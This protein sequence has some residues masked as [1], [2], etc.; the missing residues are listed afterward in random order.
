MIVVGLGIMFE[1]HDVCA[2]SVRTY[3]V[4]ELSSVSSVVMFTTGEGVFLDDTGSVY[5]TANEWSTWRRIQPPNVD[6]T[7]RFV[8][9]DLDTFRNGSIVIVGYLMPRSDEVPKRSITYA[10]SSGDRGQTWTE[11]GQRDTGKWISIA[12]GDYPFGIGLRELYHHDD[13]LQVSSR[14]LEFL[15]SDLSYLYPWGTEYGPNRSFSLRCNRLLFQA[16]NPARVHRID[17]TT[18]AIVGYQPCLSGEG[19][20]PEAITS[21]MLVSKNYGATFWFTD[22][23]VDRI[24]MEILSNPLRCK[25][26]RFDDTIWSGIAT[27]SQTR[28]TFDGGKSWG[29]HTISVDPDSSIVTL[30][31]GSPMM[32]PFGQGK[33]LALDRN[34]VDGSTV[35]RCT[36][37]DLRTKNVNVVGTEFIL[38]EDDSVSYSYEIVCVY[39]SLRKC[40][41][42]V[43]RYSPYAR[44]K[45]IGREFVVVTLPASSND[46]LPPSRDDGAKSVHISREDGILRIQSSSVKISSYAV[47][48][49]I[50][51][52]LITQNVD[53]M[54]TSLSTKSLA[55]Q[56]IY[57]CI[58][59]VDGSYSCQL[60][61]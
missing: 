50:G 13:L 30:P 32:Y 14:V 11:I 58:S 25:V 6:S 29:E 3:P 26:F 45:L 42:V 59:L 54:T 9:Q 1:S 17:T 20:Q 2:Q 10:M 46:T 35:I 41:I 36:K 40:L 44:E 51:E 19:N 15:T 12:C 43:D 53:T 60:V 24:S 5:Q 8:P 61:L 7:H 47:Y 4:P 27:T 31:I 21:Y 18:F 23:I 57:V 55:V 33:A 38:E 52:Q 39:D 48:T 22:S 34:V 37:V 56:P 28:S 16:Q 49:L